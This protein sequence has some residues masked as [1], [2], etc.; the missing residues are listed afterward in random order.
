MKK[1]E[2]VVNGIES[3][4]KVV[5]V[6]G[7]LICGRNSGD[8]NVYEEGEE[9]WYT[10]EWE[11]YSEE[12]EDNGLSIEDVKEFIGDGVCFD[13]GDDGFDVWENVYIEGNDVVVKWI[14]K[15]I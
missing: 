1:L 6:I 13:Y 4:N 5:N 12:F 14:Y 8:W 7:D 9:V 3:D 15:E 2:R 10:F 11:D